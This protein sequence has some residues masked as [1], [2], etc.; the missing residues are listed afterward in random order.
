MNRTCKGAL[1]AVIAAAG[2]SIA[3]MENRTASAAPQDKA[4]SEEQAKMQARSLEIAK[5]YHDAGALG[6]QHADMSRYL[7]EWDVKLRFQY[8]PD[9]PVETTGSAT[10][11]WL[12]E[13]R[14]LLEEFECEFNGAPFKGYNL[15]GFD[16]LKQQYMTCWVDNMS[17]SLFVAS[18]AMDPSN[19]LLTTYSQ[20]D[21]FVRGMRNKPIQTTTKFVDEN[22]MIYTTN[23]VLWGQ[24]QT[25]MEATYTRRK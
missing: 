24:T 19:S 15:I 14:W 8:T 3:A 5:A 10:F 6:D 21:D 11:R 1:L 22:K 2:L 12:L 18:G 7:G 9:H 13:G 20:V 25:V 4:T 16:N 17:T 23:D